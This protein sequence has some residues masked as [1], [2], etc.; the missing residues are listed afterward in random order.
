LRRASTHDDDDADEDDDDKDDDDENADS[1]C[2]SRAPNF[3]EARLP[4][5]QSVVAFKSSVGPP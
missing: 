3:T 1:R 5:L 4:Y 2:G